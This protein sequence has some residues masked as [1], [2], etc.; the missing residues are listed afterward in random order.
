MYK[1]FAHY[2]AWTDSMV[3]RHRYIGLI[4]Y[5]PK[6]AGGMVNILWVIAPNVT[7]AFEAENAADKMLEQF[8]EI[9]LS[10]NV[11]YRDGV[12]L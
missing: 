1:D 10:G 12:L 6:Q 9:T 8:D 2:T 4:E 11:I 7:C 3:D 5:Q